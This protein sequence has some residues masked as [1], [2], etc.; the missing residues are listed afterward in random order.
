LSLLRNREFSKLWAGQTISVFG[1]QITT[2]A[3]PLAAVLTLDASA[4]QM[5]LLTALTWLPHLLFSLH[6]GVFI[7]R[8]ARK[9]QTMI[10][11]DIARALVL[12]SVPLAY[13]FDVLTIWQLFA[14]AFL[15]GTCAVFFDLSWSTIFVAL[16]PR[17]QFVDAN[18]KLFQSRSLSYVA[19]PSVAG[20]LVQ[21]LRAPLA[22]LADALSFLASAFILWRIHATEPPPEKETGERLRTRL[23]SGLRFIWHNAAY[24]A[25]L[26]SFSTMNFFNLMFSALFVLYAT[27]ELNVKPGTLGLV[28]GAGA[29]G[30][31]IGAVFAPRLS[32]RIGVGQSIVVGSLL[33]PAP[34]ML[35]PAAGGPQWL[36]LTFLAVAQFFAGMGV[37]ILDVNGNSLGAALSPDRMR[38]RIA[39]AHRTINYGVRPA[40]ALLAGVLAE[41]IGLRPTL[42]I[43]SIGALLG[44]LWL[45]PSPIPHMRDLPESA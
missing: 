3:L 9:R 20:F 6:A 1:D 10:V 11:A 15:H 23:A 21:V 17:E 36:V 4:F 43:A 28:L 44:V 30:A 16:V 39:G 26:L 7:D 34:L 24:R 42:W 35:I 12:A 5:G 32:R 18:S 25:S 8:H 33:F 38:A 13:A 29:V 14:V 22:L 2:L 41:A 40:G 19:G 31:V 27:K 45:L 37:M